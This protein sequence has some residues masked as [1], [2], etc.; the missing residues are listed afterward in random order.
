MTSLLLAVLTTA[1]IP[2]APGQEA[3]D[4]PRAS[5][6]APFVGEETFAVLH[7]DLSSLDIDGLAR[8]LLAGFM[9]P[10]EVDEATGGLSSWVE[11]LREAGARSFFLVVDP[12]DLPGLPIA[13]VPM[14]EGADAEAIGR[15]LCGGGEGADAAFPVSWPTCA[16]FRG[17][18]FAGTDA[19]LGRLR[20][21]EPVARPG[22]DA[23]FAAPGDAPV[24]LLIAPSDDQRRVVEEML[25]ALPGPLEGTPVSAL[26]RGMR[27]AALSLE[28]QPR[29]TL[30]L[31]IQAAD[32]PAARQL[33]DLARDGLG[34]VKAETGGD[35]SMAE[36]ARDLDRIEI[37]VEGNRLELVADLEQAA[38]LVGAPLRRARE[39]AKR[40]QC[41]NNIKQLGLAMHNYHERHKS[42]PPAY[43]T[44]AE[45]RP[46]LSWRV[47]LLA[48]LEEQ[49]LFDEFH[50]DEP[51][52]SPHNAAL[53]SRMPDVFRC[54]SANLAEDGL[55]TYLVPR[56]ESTIFP[57]A[58]R[59]TLKEITDGTSNTVFVIDAGPDLA[60]P[61]TR[62]A[63]WEAGEGDEPDLGGLFGNHPGGTNAGFADGSV[64]FLREEIDPGTWRKLLTIAGGEAFG[65][66]DY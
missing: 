41:V 20:G 15:I 39:A 10:R 27:W 65:P 43:S 25:P 21:R 16:T 3:P 12:A 54:P 6:V 4:A 61:W 35:A 56:G 42:F 59:V 62:P 66:D 11:S 36:F 50:L 24:R 33:E 19:A 32:E 45:G 52:D 60:V 18:V 64:R 49:T 55:T 5:A 23:A 8:R 44:D 22:F 30:R 1:P 28:D 29:P 9:T 63:D 14:T 47:H 53:I 34:W 31:A 13:V 2:P 48:F 51:W 40:A 38:A 57:G 26:S 7:V 17:A 37:R 58:E 46:L